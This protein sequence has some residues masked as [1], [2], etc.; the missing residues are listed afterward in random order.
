VLFYNRFL[1][2]AEALQI[3]NAVQATHGIS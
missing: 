3:T 2:D 1:S